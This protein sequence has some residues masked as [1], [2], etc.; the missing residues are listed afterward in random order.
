MGL[1]TTRKILSVLLAVVIALSVAVLLPSLVLSTTAQ[2][3]PFY[4]RAFITE[5]ITAECSEELSAAYA[6]LEAETGIPARVFETV[7]EGSSVSDS[8]KT[9]LENAFGSEDA[10]LYSQNMVTYFYNLCTEYLDGNGIAYDE[11]RVMNAADKAAR[12]FSDIV[13]LHGVEAVKAKA[14]VIRYEAVGASTLA[15]FLM[16]LCIIMIVFMYNDTRKGIVYAAS[17]AAGGAL[18]TLL[19]SLLSALMGAGSHVRVTPAVYQTAM[20]RIFVANDILTALCA[21]VMAL[22]T[23]IRC[24]AVW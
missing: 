10:T 7:K 5:D 14:D 2:S 15:A 17:G 8:L 24:I 23:N 21:L 6:A 20:H 1:A 4:E 19:G 9:A 18:G 22:A 3:E 11:T 12:I 16:V 13:G